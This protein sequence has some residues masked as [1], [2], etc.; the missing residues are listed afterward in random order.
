MKIS[1]KNLNILKTSSSLL[2]QFKVASTLKMTI[3]LFYKLYLDPI[4]V[5]PSTDVIIAL[6]YNVVM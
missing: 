2:I 6:L 5:D 1:E 3:F 4:C